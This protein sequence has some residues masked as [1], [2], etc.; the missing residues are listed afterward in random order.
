M[1]QTAGTSA[2]IEAELVPQPSKLHEIINDERLKYKEE[3]QKAQKDTTP[4]GKDRRARI[5]RIAQLLEEVG[6]NA[7]AEI[8]AVLERKVKHQSMEQIFKEGQIAE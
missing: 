6:D 5:K 8:E 7:V 2:T 3:S 1:V 4:Q